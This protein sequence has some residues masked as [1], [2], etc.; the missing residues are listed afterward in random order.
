M[1]AEA[2]AKERAALASFVAAREGAFAEMR[3]K[4][5]EEV[6]QVTSQTCLT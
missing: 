5:Q 4:V 1:Q 2:V 6:G 3:A